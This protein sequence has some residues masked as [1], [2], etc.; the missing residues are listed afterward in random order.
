[1][2]RI[3]HLLSVLA[4]I[5]KH[6]DRAAAEWFSKGCRQYL[7]GAQDTLDKAC[8][9]TSTSGK[10]KARTLW[11]RQERDRLIRQAMTFIDPDLGHTRRCELLADQIRSF[12]ARIWPR[13]RDLDEL[14]AEVSELRKSLW[15][16]KR[17]G[18]S[19]PATWRGVYRSVYGY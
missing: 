1:M 5:N 9:L 2:Q 17:T 13:L 16:A 15:L 8:G 3:K 7:T 10:Y 11:A 19:L 14:P 12:E 4:T 18:A 6:G